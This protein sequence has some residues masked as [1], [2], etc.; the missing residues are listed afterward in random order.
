M[1]KSLDQELESVVAADDGEAAADEGVVKPVAQAK[2]KSAVGLGILVV[3]LCMVGGIIA[4]VM[5][6]FKEAA[7]YALPADELKARAGELTGRKVRVD[8][9]LVPGTLQKRDDPCEY[10]FTIQAKGA[11]LTVRY[12]QCVVPDTFRD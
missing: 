11:E 3:L 1:K 8:G 5:L 7:V 4:L 12:P 2:P 6:G 10:R 9:E